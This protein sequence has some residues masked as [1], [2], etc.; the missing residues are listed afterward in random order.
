MSSCHAN[1]IQRISFVTDR[2]AVQKQSPAMTDIAVL[3]YT[4]LRR[5]IY[6][7]GCETHLALLSKLKG[8]VFEL[9]NRIPRLSPQGAL[10]AIWA[11]SQPT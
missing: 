4:E 5:R 3:V 9:D 7:S 8:T 2:L 11:H 1:L 6:T 10:L